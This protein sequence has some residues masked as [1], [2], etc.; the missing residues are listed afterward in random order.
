MRQAVICGSVMAS[1]V[2]E[3]FSLNRIRALDYEEILNRYRE[4]KRLT[5]FE[6]AGDIF[7]R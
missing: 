5:H 7:N 4:F 6:D 3:D 1:F 2:V